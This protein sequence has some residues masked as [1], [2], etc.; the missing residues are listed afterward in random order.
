MLNNVR[1]V[2][3][4]YCYNNFDTYYFIDMIVIIVAEV[5]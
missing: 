1:Q 4:Q 2:A 3:E 5:V